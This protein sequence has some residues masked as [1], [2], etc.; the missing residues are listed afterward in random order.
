[1][2]DQQ[3]IRQTSRLLGITAFCLA[4]SA[5]LAILFFYPPSQYPFYP[6]CP[7]QRLFHLQCPGCGSTR[8]FAALLHGRLR[9]ALRL[10]PLTICALPAIALDSIYRWTAPLRGKAPATWSTSPAALY[11]GWIVVAVFTILRNL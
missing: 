2:R 9:E 7:I 1:M 5:V 4:I 10:N 11:A 8:A 6:A 3:Q